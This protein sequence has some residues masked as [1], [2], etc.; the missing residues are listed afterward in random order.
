MMNAIGIPTKMRK[1][2]S[3]DPVVCTPFVTLATK[4]CGVVDPKKSILV[5]NYSNN[6]STISSYHMRRRFPGYSFD[7]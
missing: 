6:G 5:K 4:S 7:L 2:Q 3:A 1:G